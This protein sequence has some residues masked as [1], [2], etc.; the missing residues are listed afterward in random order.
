MRPLTEQQLGALRLAPIDTV[1]NRVGVAMALTGAAQ[2]EIVEFTGFA[3]PYVSDVRRGRFKNITVGNARKFADFFGCAIE[4]LFPSPEG[5]DRSQPAL[6]FARKA[7]V[8]R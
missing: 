2:I 7:A 4:D 1:P 8:A 3:Q 5:Q 6:P